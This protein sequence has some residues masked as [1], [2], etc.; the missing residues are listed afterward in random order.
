[1][2]GIVG[3]V[4]VDVA[5]GSQPLHLHGA[6]PGATLIGVSTGYTLS[7]NS[8]T[9]AFQWVLEHQRKP[10]AA[11]TAQ[12][13]DLDPACPPIKVTNN[14][15]GNPGG[16]ASNANDV[17]VMLQ[18]QLLTK[19]VVTVWA[20][21]NDGGDGTGTGTGTPDSM[22]KPTQTTNGPGMDPMGGILMVASYNDGGNGTRDGA[23]SGF[24]SRGLANDKTTWPDISAP[25]DLITSS[26]RAQLPVCSTGAG[27]IT[28]PGTGGLPGDFNTISGTSMATPHIAGIV[29]QLFQAQPT[30]TPA[31]IELA[32]ENSAHKFTA[33]APYTADLTDRNATDTTSYDKGHGLVDVVGAVAQLRGTIPAPAPVQQCTG[34]VITDARGDATQA[35]TETGV[36]QLND[37]SLD[38]IT[39]RLLTRADGGLDFVLRVDDLTPPTAYGQVVEWTATI[40][41]K[42][43]QLLAT[44]GTSGAVSSDLEDFGGPN[45]TRRSIAPLAAAFNDAA[46][47]VT[48]TLPTNLSAAAAPRFTTGNAVGGLSITTRRSIGVGGVAI[49]PNADSATSG[50]PYIVG[51]AADGTPTAAVPEAPYAVLLLVTGLGGAAVL[52]R[53]RRLVTA[54]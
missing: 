5:R 44:R 26:C 30:A 4:D 12:T 28:G 17:T 23:L 22:G 3:G 6:A 40:G 11:V 53:R 34:G 15:Y 21:G 50:C 8:A 18:R 43:Y 54:G 46:D 45:G 49:I 37:P 2:A 33:G 41:S 27:P 16:S 10:C 14:S 47:T 9:L 31:Q 25:G 42:T 20:A 24:S 35:L 13:G 52:V 48:I 51:T 1:M 36:S 19:G 29:A 7:I 39:G 38:I 32:I